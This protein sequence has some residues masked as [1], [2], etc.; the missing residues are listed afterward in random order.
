MIINN[1]NNNNNN[2]AAFGILHHQGSITGLRMD[3][4][5]QNLKIYFYL[6]YFSSAQ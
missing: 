5:L 6:Y 1:N 3:L 2:L 4:K